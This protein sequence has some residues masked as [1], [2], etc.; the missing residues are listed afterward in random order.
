TVT[1]QGTVSPMVPITARWEQTG[2]EPEVDIIGSEAPISTF[3]VP[4]C[5]EIEGDAT[6]TFRLT[7]IDGQGVTDVASANFVVTDAVA[8]DEEEG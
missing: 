6:L 3:A 8:A 2:G 5:D 1:L 7:V 4:G